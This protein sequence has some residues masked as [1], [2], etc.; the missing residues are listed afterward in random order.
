MI[1]RQFDTIFKRKAYLSNYLNLPLFNSDDTEFKECRELL[2]NIA[3]EYKQAESPDYLTW[4][5]NP[6]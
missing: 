2:S 1:G 6:N 4:I 5:Q 3:K